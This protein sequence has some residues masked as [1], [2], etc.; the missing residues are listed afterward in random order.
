MGSSFPVSRVLL[1]MGAQP[2]PLVA[3]RFFIAAVIAILIT[4]WFFPVTKHFATPAMVLTAVIVG[5]FQTGGVMS[6]IFIAM[7]TVDPAI[8][9]AILFSNVLLV[10]AIDAASGKRRWNL[11]LIA[12]LLLGIGGLALVT[13]AA[14][15]IF[16]T[17]RQTNS[18]FGEWLC[19]GATCCWACATLISKRVKPGDPWRFNNVQMM[20]G[21]IAVAATAWAQGDQLWI[22]MDLVTWSWFLWLVIPASIGSFG[23]WFSALQQRSASETSAWLFLV[24]VFAAVIAW[25]VIGTMPSLTQ[26]L[27]AALIGIAL[28]LQGQ[29][30]RPSDK[31]E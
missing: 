12:S 23:L 25:P 8:V 19:V 5:V 29:K 21:S 14:H 18:H 2:L 16:A 22:P 24:P 6:L 27:G 4:R 1:D 3:L 17:S 15:A 30:S 28:F 10:A 26:T 31:P 20:S 11:L 7:Q 13:G 9:A